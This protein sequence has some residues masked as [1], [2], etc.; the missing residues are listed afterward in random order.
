MFKKLSLFL[1]V[2]LLVGVSLHASTPKAMPRIEGTIQ[3]IDTA[4]NAITIQSGNDTKTFTMN[5]KT[6]FLMNGKHVK[7]ADLKAGESVNIEAD[8]KNVARRIEL[9][10]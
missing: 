5:S 8:A 10:K 2:A 7:S 9:K 3:T 4:K 1:F 6:A